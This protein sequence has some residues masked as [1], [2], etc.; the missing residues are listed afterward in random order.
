MCWWG[1]YSWLLPLVQPPT[2][3]AHGLQGKSSARGDF[4]LLLDQSLAR[5]EPPSWIMKMNPGQVCPERALTKRRQFSDCGVWIR[6]KLN[7]LFQHVDTT[8]EPVPKKGGTPMPFHTHPVPPSLATGRSCADSWEEASSW[9]T[10][11]WLIDTP[12]EPLGQPG[13][14]GGGGR[15]S[16]Q[17]GVP[18][19]PVFT[20]RT[21]VAQQSI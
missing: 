6:A 16:I 12:A 17:Q 21:M 3:P 10:L 5:S 9:P 15:G 8:P 11:A 4:L 7:S 2:T 14:Q 18:G 19:S 20:L 13:G 1:N